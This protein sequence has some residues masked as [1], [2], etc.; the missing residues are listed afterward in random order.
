M[1]QII[2]KAFGVESADSGVKSVLRGRVTVTVLYV[3]FDWVAHFYGKTDKVDSQGSAMSLSLDEAVKKNN[4]VR[5]QD[6]NQKR[7]F[8]LSAALQMGPLETVTH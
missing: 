2:E 3:V 1:V 5:V 7:C 8:E 6:L 4:L